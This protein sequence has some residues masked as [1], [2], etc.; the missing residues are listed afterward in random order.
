MSAE[1]T[2]FV[3]SHVFANTRPVL[4]VGREDGDLMFSCGA[5]HPADEEYHA[6]GLAHLLERDSTLNQVQD[7]EDNWEAERTAAGAPWAWQPMS[8]RS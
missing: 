6:M 5:E 2:A 4:L 8:S 3:C 1:R 7:L